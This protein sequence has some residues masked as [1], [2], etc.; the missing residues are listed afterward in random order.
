MATRE[1]KLRIIEQLKA[2]IEFL[3]LE[4]AKKEDMQ[5]RQRRSGSLLRTGILLLC[6]AVG[7]CLGAHF[8]F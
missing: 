4:L 5:Q 3:R 8:L 1:E 7:F 2:D 6:L